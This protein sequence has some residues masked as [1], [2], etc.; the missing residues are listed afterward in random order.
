M[1]CGSKPNSA[2]N[3]RQST[4]FRVSIS[5]AGDQW[6]CSWLLYVFRREFWWDDRRQ[7]KQPNVSKTQVNS[8]RSSLLTSVSPWVA[9]VVAVVIAIDELPLVAQSAT[10]AFMRYCR[11]DEDERVYALLPSRWRRTAT[12]N[13]FNDREP[14]PF[15]VWAF[16]QSES[17]SPSGF[18]SPKSPAEPKHVTRWRLR[19]VLNSRRRHSSGKNAE[20][21]LL[22]HLFKLFH[23]VVCFAI[24]VGATITV[25]AEAGCNR[26]AWVEQHHCRT[27]WKSMFLRKKICCH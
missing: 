9:V 10:Y 3:S 1:G 25:G 15:N 18:A 26:S 24:I 27:P 2:N 13:K 8:R 4:L 11:A 20:L 17:T 21:I 14:G 5:F 12:S 6:D 22:I 16:V 7:N 19:Q 23:F